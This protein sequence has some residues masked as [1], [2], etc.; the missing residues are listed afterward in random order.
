MNEP[1]AAGA[2]R[3]GT[4]DNARSRRAFTVHLGEMLVAM[5]LGMMLL[6]GVSQLA[7]L[8]AG[9][10][11]GEASGAVQVLLMG[12]NMTVPMVAWM[13]YRGHDRARTGEMAASMAIPSLGATALAVGVL[14]ADAALAAQHGLMIPAMLGVMLRRYDHY[15]RPVGR[16]PQAPTFASEPSGSTSIPG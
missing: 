5:F 13:R 3:D 9:S 2:P 11:L 10:N 14:S 1:I 12:F 6:G 7:L 15:A 8:A 16:R 4:C